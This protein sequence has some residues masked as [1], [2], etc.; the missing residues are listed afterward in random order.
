MNVRSFQGVTIVTLSIAVLGCG[1]NAAEHGHQHEQD[2]THAATDPHDHD[3]PAE[4]PHGGRLIE[5]GQNEITAEL[6]FH[7]ER[8]EVVIH[9]SAVGESPSPAGKPVVGIQL[10]EDG[11]FVDYP[12]NP[13]DDQTVFSLQDEKVHG[14]L[15][16]GHVKGRLRVSWGG[17]EYS[18]PLDG[19]CH[20]H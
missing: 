7:D 11:Q 13:V 18:A 19:I 20:G 5:L 17:K 3:H 9:L 15:D 10:F 4:G 1:S 12:V 16:A 14:I 2:A 6:V 8:H